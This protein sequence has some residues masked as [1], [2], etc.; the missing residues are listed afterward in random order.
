M[1]LYLHYNVPLGHQCSRTCGRQLGAW[2]TARQACV[3][4]GWRG[5]G[6]AAGPH[7]ARCQKQC[8][9]EGCGAPASGLSLASESGPKDSPGTERE[10]RLKEKLE[11]DPGK[12]QYSMKSSN[13]REM[14][15]SSNPLLPPLV[16]VASLLS[17]PAALVHVSLLSSLENN[18]WLFSQKTDEE[19]FTEPLKEYKRTVTSLLEITFNL[20]EKSVHLHIFLLIKL[21]SNPGKTRKHYIYEPVRPNLWRKQNAVKKSY[22]TPWFSV[23]RGKK[24]AKHLPVVHLPLE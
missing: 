16:D 1:F 14:C 18:M 7:T 24:T 4:E 6:C 17:I 3:P 22:K 11:N 13:T 15:K 8:T 12:K 23:N 10:T 5:A 9:G 20:T 19:N 2:G 21:F